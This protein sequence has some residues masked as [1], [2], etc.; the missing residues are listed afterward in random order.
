MSG[1]GRDVFVLGVGM[2]RFGG[3]PKRLAERA[4]TAG[5]NALDDGGVDF[6]EVGCLYLGS[7]LT[8]PCFGIGVVKDLGLTGIP[9][10]RVES[11]SASG[12]AAFYE[13]VQ[14][15]ASGRVDIAMALGYDDPASAGGLNTMRAGVPIIEAAILPAA[16]FAFWA[17]RR[18]H[19]HGTTPETLAAIAAKNWNNA[20]LNPYAERQATS[21]VTVE[22]VLKSRMLAYPHTSRMAAPQGAGAA[23]AI[24]ASGAALER[25]QPGARRVRVAAA[26]A[27]S[28]TYG[29]GHLFVGAVVGPPD[30]A[31]RGAFAAYEEAAIG[32]EDLD[33]V[34]FHDAYAIEELLYYEEVGL[35]GPGEGDKLVAEGA[36]EI[37]GRVAASTDGGFIGRGHPSGPSGLAQIWEL[38]QQLRGTAEARQ[39]PG[40][41][42]GLAHIM[43]AGSCCYAHLLTTA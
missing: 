25:L 14:A 24:V 10:T 38:T 29:D 31:R 37:G 11:A 7:S 2:D 34:S 3:P 28:E 40:A 26:Q 22:D 19:D 33:V 5:V 13:A 42:V 8:A 17:V 43:G 20:A 4:F 35:C 30:M 32:P 36:T 18:M 27:T 12:A 16:F 6:R 15:V 39:Q 41:Q 9:I 21:T 1:L 23:A